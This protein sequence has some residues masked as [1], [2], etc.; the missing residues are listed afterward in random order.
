ME[1]TSGLG[2]RKEIEY[3]GELLKRRPVFG[4]GLGNYGRAK[5]EL[6]G[7][8]PWSKAATRAAHNTYL[9]IG[10]EVGIIGMTIFILVVVSAIANCMWSRRVFKRK[11]DLFLLHKISKGIGIGL[12]GFAVCIFFLSEQYSSLL[13]QW[14]GLTVAL[15]RIAEE[16]LGESH[17][18]SELG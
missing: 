13:Y 1:D 12:I 7:V 18:W 5:I 14:F 3:A 17:E 2:R 11:D 10:V 16:R 15:R 9:G 4:V 8:D 6:L